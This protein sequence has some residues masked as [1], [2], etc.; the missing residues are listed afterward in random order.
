MAAFLKTS[1]PATII[2]DEFA[3][4]ERIDGPPGAGFLLLC[5]HASN[6]LPAAYGTLGLAAHD[7]EAH[8]A[9]DIGAAHVTRRLAA[10]FNAPALL[11]CFS[12]LL[13]DPNRGAHDPTLVM[14]LSDRRLVPGNAR[15]TAAEI[16]RR[17]DLYWR[18]YH[19]AIDAAI[20]VMSAHGP[21]P[22]VMSIHSFTPV[23]RG[24]RRPWQVGVLWD[25]DSRLAE[26]LIHALRARGLVVGDNEPYS[27]SL[28]GDTLHTHVTTRGL[29][30][31]LIELRQ[32]LIETPAKAHGWADL[33]AEVLRPILAQPQMHQIAI[34][35]CR[36]GRRRSDAE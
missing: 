35:P 15:I 11:T 32:D 16:A 28:P 26:P 31:L 27:G 36:A 8:I 12:R 17:R 33:L 20:E 13:I 21:I 23:W 19:V 9:Y 24:V 1:M 6:E 10:R 4:F 29:A 25:S 22:A 3:P 14:R 30:G 7:L 34:G 18:P 2:S 5:D